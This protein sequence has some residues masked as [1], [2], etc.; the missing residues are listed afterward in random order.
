MTLRQLK[1]RRD[2]L[3]KA[4]LGRLLDPLL[5]WTSDCLAQGDLDEAGRLLTWGERIW[6]VQ[7]ART[8][9]RFRRCWPRRPIVAR[10]GDRLN[11]EVEWLEVPVT[12]LCTTIRS[13]GD[14][15]VAAWTSFGLMYVL[16]C[17]THA[18]AIA[19]EERA[20]H[21]ARL[22][23][24]GDLD[25]IL[26]RAYPAE[27]AAWETRICG[28]DEAEGWRLREANARRA[29]YFGKMLRALRNRSETC[30]ANV[31]EMRLRLLS[32]YPAPAL[33]E[34]S[35]GCK[36][37]EQRFHLFRQ[38]LDRVDLEERSKVVEL[39]AEALKR[40]I[41]FLGKKLEAD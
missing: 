14:R 27:H 20:L 24:I 1:R 6:T 16:E 11:R 17:I 31:S 19:H 4:D 5:A 13:G 3:I 37:P 32:R 18:R 33:N 36:S 21:R 15:E 39:A 41:T 40:K 25:P 10:P 22:A 7:L 12:Q 35:A 30:A 28:V 23:R 9:S 2:R 26:L 29:I 8:Q 38:L 34:I